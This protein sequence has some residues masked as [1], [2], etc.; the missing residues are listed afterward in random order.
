MSITSADG[1]SR[2]L[3]PCLSWRWLCAAIDFSS[4]LLLGTPLS[5]GKG[6]PRRRFLSALKGYCNLSETEVLI[7]GFRYLTVLAKCDLSGDL[8]YA[9]CMRSNQFYYT[10]SGGP[11]SARHWPAAFIYHYN[12]QRP[13]QVLDNRI[14]VA[15]ILNS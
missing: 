7:D 12:I 8:E 14:P 10:W 4:K 15:E 5:P 1:G 9:D 2:L 6:L 3:K 13:N 11:A